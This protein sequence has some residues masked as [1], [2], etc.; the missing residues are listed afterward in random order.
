M[1][2]SCWQSVITINREHTCI[3]QPRREHVGIREISNGHLIPSNLKFEEYAMID[4][5]LQVMYLIS[6]SEITNSIAKTNGD[7]DNSNESNSD[8]E[9]SPVSINEAYNSVQTLFSVSQTQTR[10][11][12]FLHLGKW[13]L[14]GASYLCVELW[15]CAM[16]ASQNHQTDIPFTS[17]FWP[18]YVTQVAKNSRLALLIFTVGYSLRYNSA[19]EDYLLPFTYW[20]INQFAPTFMRLDKV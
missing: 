3:R 9:Q 6:D 17:S 12:N 10:A 8:G 18:M 11:E 4:H 19:S 1:D 15:R 2:F 7:A 20:P 13:K 16:S 5:Q 14:P